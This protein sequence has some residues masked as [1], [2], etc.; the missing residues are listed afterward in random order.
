MLL[1]GR[2]Q[3]RFHDRA[4]SSDIPS[5]RL[6]LRKTFID[7]GEQDR[8][9]ERLAQ[10]ARGTEPGGHSL[11]VGLRREKAYPEIAISGIVG[12]RR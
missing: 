1:G 4:Q 8:R 12:A 9:L 2:S 3:Q 7:H 5:A 10:A 6:G 11:E